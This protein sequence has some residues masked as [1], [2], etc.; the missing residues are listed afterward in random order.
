MLH[1]KS[2][3]IKNQ[4]HG[5]KYFACIPPPPLTLGLRLKGQNSTLSEHRHVENQIKGNHECIDM[6]ANIFPTDPLHHDHMDGVNRSKFNF[7]EHGHVA[8]P[9]TPLTFGLDNKGKKSSECGHV[10]YQIKGKEVW[11][12]TE[13]N[14]LTLYTPLRSWRNGIY[15]L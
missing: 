15:V 5:R 11:N 3:E 4:H 1:I 12:N 7:S 8:S 9:Y 2:K 10:A 6:V 13:A 14:T